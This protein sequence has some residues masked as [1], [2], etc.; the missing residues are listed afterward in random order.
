MW[1]K[2]RNIL[3]ISFNPAIFHNQ[4]NVAVTQGKVMFVTPIK[5]ELAMLLQIDFYYSGHFEIMQS[6]HHEGKK[7]MRFTSI[8]DRRVRGK[9]D[10]YTLRD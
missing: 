10:C 6:S 5:V 2:F 1:I 4:V 9:K 7:I 3:L 8:L